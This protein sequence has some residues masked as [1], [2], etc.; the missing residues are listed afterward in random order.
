[1]GSM[2]DF[3]LAGVL[4]SNLG[5]SICQLFLLQKDMRFHLFSKIR[6]L[7]VSLCAAHILFPS[8]CTPR[9]RLPRQ[10][11]SCI[12]FV[13]AADEA[14]LT[15]KWSGC[16]SVAWIQSREALQTHSPDSGS[17]RAA[18]GC[19]LSHIWPAKKGEADGSDSAPSQ[20]RHRHVGLSFLNYAVINGF[21]SQPLNNVQIK[22]LILPKR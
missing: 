10:M 20:G 8:L 3:W 7:S 2:W 4:A 18:L 21:P 6:V 11:S 17:P 14:A 5:Y 22:L 15:P 16:S 12:P 1:M 13:P 19:K 9:L